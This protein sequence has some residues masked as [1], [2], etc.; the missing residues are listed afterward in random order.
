MT[1]TAFLLAAAVSLTGCATAIAGTPHPDP[2]VTAQLAKERDCRA[3]ADRLI[4]AVSTMVKRVDGG[5]TSM[6]TVSA[7]M[8]E[9]P[10]QDIGA[11]IGRICGRDLVGPEYSRILVEV[12]ALSPATWFGRMA[13]Q[14]TLTGLCSLDG[15]SIPINEQARVVCAGR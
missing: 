14:A 10:I 11:D 3:A 4:G 2:A 8:A 6:G 12:N 5:G 15:T 9:L 7:M 1:L 13:Q